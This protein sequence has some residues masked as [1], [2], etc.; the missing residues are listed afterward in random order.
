MARVVNGVDIDALQNEALLMRAEMI[1]TTIYWAT[2]AV[3]WPF[4][5]VGEAVE[6]A[7]RYSELNDLSDRQ[8]S[9]MGIAREQIAALI[10]GVPVPGVVGASVHV[11]DTS[12][13]PSG[14]RTDKL[15]A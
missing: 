9:D 13:R 5:I 6:M 8:L 1:A 15:A 3:A 4:R 12:R 14:S 2:K 11:L 7:R 10:S